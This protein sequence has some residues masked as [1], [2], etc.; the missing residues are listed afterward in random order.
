VST[1]RLFFALWPDN[2]QRDRLRDVISSVAKVVEGSAVDRRLWHVTLPFIGDFEESRIPELQN[3]AGLIQVEP[4]RLG[5]DRL[6]YWVRPKVACLVPSTVPAEL[7]SLVTS[8]NAILEQFGIVPQDRTYRPH[9]TVSRGAR[10]FTTERLTP[11]VVTEWSGFELMES[12]S[13][14]GGVNYIPLQ[15]SI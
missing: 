13:G 9:I 2:R 10:S 15:Q 11:R 1:K 4:F 8:L 14:P 5:F 12:L 7:D 6:E 3:L